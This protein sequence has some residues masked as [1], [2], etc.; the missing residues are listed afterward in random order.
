MEEA[1]E[2]ED[3][4]ERKDVRL[5]KEAGG[6]G[7]LPFLRL[8]GEK[9]PGLPL[10]CCRLHTET[11]RGLQHLQELPHHH[12]HQH[13]NH[14]HDNKTRDEQT[15]LNSSL[16]HV[17]QQTRLVLLQNLYTGKQESEGRA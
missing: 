3:L 2:V 4:E 9:V 12:R 13:T 16:T 8:G 7:G 15:T 6:Q 17:P 11:G 10:A 1:L 5:E 14:R